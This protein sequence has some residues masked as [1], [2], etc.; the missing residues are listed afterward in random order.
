MAGEFHF[1]TKIVGLS[2]GFGVPVNP[3]AWQVRDT[4]S[5]QVVASGVAADAA[6][7]DTAATAALTTARANEKTRLTNDKSR[8]AAE[9][10]A[11]PS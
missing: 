11:L 6:A 4:T 1:F 7:A 10:A 3:A 9:I 5:G 2:P 8:S